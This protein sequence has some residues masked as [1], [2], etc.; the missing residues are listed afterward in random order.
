MRP[1]FKRFVTQ[2]GADPSRSWRRFLL[3]LFF[4]GVVARRFNRLL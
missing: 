3:G 1:A 4:V 2:Y